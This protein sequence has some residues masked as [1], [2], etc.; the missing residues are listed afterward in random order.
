ML[1]LELPVLVIVTDLL[2]SLELIE[3]RR[4]AGRAAIS[5]GGIGLPSTN[6]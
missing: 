2:D 6:A 4:E 1:V 5:V 3:P